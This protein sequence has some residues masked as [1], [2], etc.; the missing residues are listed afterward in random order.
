MQKKNYCYDLNFKF[1]QGFRWIKINNFC[2]AE[3][4]FTLSLK[5]YQAD[6][7]N[8]KDHRDE[9]DE[10]ERTRPRCLVEYQV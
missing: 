3:G 10:R 9:E 4:I 2:K 5:S 7:I 8:A 6:K 1:N